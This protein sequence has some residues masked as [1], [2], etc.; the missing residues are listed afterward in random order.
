MIIGL[1]NI[2]ELRIF[3]KMSEEKNILKS[4][5]TLTGLV[6]WLNENFEKKNNKPFTVSD[7]QQYIRL[8]H[9]PYYMGG[10]L[11]EKVDNEYVKL[12]NIIKE[13]Y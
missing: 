3:V 6:K 5:I 12:Y 7:V 8:K 9:I 13:E 1:F 2:C 10:H 4:G 11:I